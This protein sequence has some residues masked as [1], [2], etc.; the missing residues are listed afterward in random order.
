[1]ISSGIKV[2]TNRRTDNTHGLNNGHTHTR[3]ELTCSLLNRQQRCAA[4]IVVLAPIAIVASHDGSHGELILV[5]LRT[6]TAN[7]RSQRAQLGLGDKS[8]IH[9]W[10][11]VPET[12]LRRHRPHL[13]CLSQDN[14]SR[15]AAARTTRSQNHTERAAVAV[16]VHYSCST[17]TA[18]APSMLRRRAPRFQISMASCRVSDVR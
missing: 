4:F 3:I 12:S 9:C 15:A 8:G 18:K 13:S 14:Q 11:Q 10:L 1:M 7:D 2:S 16:V 6:G 5:A 17:Y